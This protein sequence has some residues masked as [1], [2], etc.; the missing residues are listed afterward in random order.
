MCMKINELSSNP[1][2]ETGV[3]MQ[4]KDRAG[5]VPRPLQPSGGGLG[6]RHS[7]LHCC[8]SGDRV[9]LYASRQR[10]KS[11]AGNHRSKKD[12]KNEGR[13]DYVFEN[14]EVDDNLS[15]AKD[16]ISARF[17][18]ISHRNTGIWWEPAA[19]LFLFEH[20]GTNSALQDVVRKSR[21][22]Q[23]GQDARDSA[24]ETS[25][26]CSWNHVN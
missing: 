20:S 25:T 22:G 23:H 9:Q 17:H 14:K 18:A 11:R 2:S 8:F 24:G 6:G 10:T 3:G 4:A 1:R 19:W 21:Y 5:F 16:P 13:T 7:A 15:F 12:V 26:L